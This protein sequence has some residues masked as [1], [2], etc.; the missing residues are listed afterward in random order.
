MLS[1]THLDDLTHVVRQ[2][3]Y[4]IGMRCIAKVM[5]EG[6]RR[7]ILLLQIKERRGGRHAVLTP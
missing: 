2:K 1:G 3:D 5:A 4:A 6:K 7:A